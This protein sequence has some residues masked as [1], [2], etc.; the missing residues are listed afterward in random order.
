MQ[1][2]RFLFC[3]LLA[4]LSAAA[5]EV[6]KPNVVI[7]F[8][9]DAGYSDFHPFGDPPYATPHVESL[10]EQGLQLTQFFRKFIY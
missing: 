9:D 5:A 7:I 4:A 10:A 1:L 8:L 6:R 3:C 2:K